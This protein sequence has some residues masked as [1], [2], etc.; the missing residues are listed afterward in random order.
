MKGGIFW[1][2][3]KKLWKSRLNLDGKEHILG[4]FKSRK[5]AVEN[6]NKN[7]LSYGYR[8]MKKKKIFY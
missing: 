7:R 3:K 5:E 6:Y 2:K 4:Y 8:D 1:N